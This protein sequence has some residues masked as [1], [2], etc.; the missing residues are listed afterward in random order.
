VKDF[1]TRSLKGWV[2]L[3]QVRQ[4][5]PTA[6][7]SWWQSGHPGWAIYPVDSDTFMT[8]GAL[9]TLHVQH[10]H[11]VVPPLPPQSQGQNP[12]TSGRTRRAP[13][14][15]FA[16]FAC[17]IT[18]CVSFGTMLAF[19]VS[20]GEICGGRGCICSCVRLC[21]HGV[22]NVLVWEALSVCVQVCLSV[23]KVMGVCRVSSVAPWLLPTSR[24]PLT[25]AC[26]VL[27]ALAQRRPMFR[28]RNKSRL[29]P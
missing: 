21:S 2:P 15:F 28:G 14:P 6:V 17:C 12:A 9:D 8:T 10:E 11:L 22:C 13:F 20:S 3:G 1:F 7:A 25:L 18:C 23:S 24:R 26:F 29:L 19:P 16:A 5:Q 27:A 4:L